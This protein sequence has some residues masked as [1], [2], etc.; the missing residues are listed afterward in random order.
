[1]RLS[2][3]TMVVLAAVGAL[4]ALAVTGAVLPAASPRI[5]EI[6]PWVV[7]RA[8]G[9]TG[10]LL[11]AIEVA[12]GL[13]LSHPTNQRVWKLSKRLFPWHA[14]L[15]VFV[16]SFIALHAGL[17]AVDR[18]ADVGIV[19]ALVPGLSRYRPLPIAIGTVATYAL[20]VT[21]ITARWTRLLPTGW[22]LRLHRLSAVAFLGIWAHAVL[23]GTDTGAL[24]ALYLVTGLPILAGVVHRLWVVRA[25]RGRAALDGGPAAL[26]AETRTLQEVA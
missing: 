8:S 24:E 23:A 18:Y 21:A 15:A 2:A 10:Y 17:L 19:G 1:M 16:W 25:S 5:L 22:W 7:A 14:L 9:V 11:L 13:V 12:V 20:L 3:S 4:A 26:R 6:R